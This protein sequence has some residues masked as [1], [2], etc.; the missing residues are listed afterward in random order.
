MEFTLAVL[1]GFPALFARDFYVFVLIPVS[2]W[3]HAKLVLLHVDVLECRCLLFLWLQLNFVYNSFMIR[4]H[5]FFV[6][7]SDYVNKTNPLP[8]QRMK[9]HVLKTC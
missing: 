1:Y 3:W 9:S 7:E 8:D 4:E 5:F 2:A 6:P